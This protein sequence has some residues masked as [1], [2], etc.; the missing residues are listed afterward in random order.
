MTT[1]EAQ[2]SSVN[3]S[4]V[5]FCRS[6]RGFTLDIQL[7]LFPDYAGYQLKLFEGIGH[8]KRTPKLLN[9]KDVATGECMRTISPSE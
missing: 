6:V 5:D 9:F 2:L 8:C 1:H 4:L 7:F 3:L